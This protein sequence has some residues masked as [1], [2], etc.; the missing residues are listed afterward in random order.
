MLAG[1]AK[2]MYHLK[3]PTEQTDPP[4]PPWETLPTRYVRWFDESGRVIETADE[5]LEKERDRA[6]KLARKLQELGIDPDDL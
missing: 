1:A 2:G 6:Q 4:R 5:R 3:Y